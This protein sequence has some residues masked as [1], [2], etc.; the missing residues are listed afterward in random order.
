[1]SVTI[2]LW[3]CVVSYIALALWFFRYFRE[4]MIDDRVTADAVAAAIWP[5]VVV[6]ALGLEVYFAVT[7]TRTPYRRTRRQ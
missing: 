2:P 1:M 5:V 6:C 7:R 3:A 4:Y